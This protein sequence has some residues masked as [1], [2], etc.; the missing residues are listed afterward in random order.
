[1]DRDSHAREPSNCPAWCVGREGQ[2]HDV[3]D[4]YGVHGTHHDSHLIVVELAGSDG[5]Y[6]Y[7]KAS[8]F[9][10][11]SGADPWPAVVEVD[12]ALADVR[13]R[14]GPGS[15]WLYPPETI[16]FAAGLI[17]AARLASGT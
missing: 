6:L 3:D 12:A 5:S 17:A 10:P 7:V 11:T 2:P 15:L 8:L 4:L 16:I 1:M 9:V 13:R 14:G